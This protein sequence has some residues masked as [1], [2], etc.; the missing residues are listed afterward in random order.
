VNVLEHS[1]NELEKSLWAANKLK[2]LYST[3][4]DVEVEDKVLSHSLL[5]IDTPV[6]RR[7]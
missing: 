7:M 6:I 3:R 1:Y 2:S 4:C 5:L